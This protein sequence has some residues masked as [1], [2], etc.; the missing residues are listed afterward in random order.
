M[1]HD[2][3]RPVVCHVNLA[4]G[5]RGGER[6]TELLVCELARQGLRQRLVGRRGEPL[7]ERLRH[8]ER[9]EV[10]ETGAGP[11]AAALAIG[12]A[13][14]VHV[15]E[16][17]S[18]RSAW[19]NSVFTGTP[20]VVTRRVQKGPRSHM[21]NRH[22]YRRASAVAVLSRA[23]G[24][25]MSSLCPELVT[26]VIP[27]AASGLPSSSEQA[28]RLR[29]SWGGKF[30]VG[31]VGVLDDTHKGQTQIL[32]LAAG[33]AAT[34]PDVRFVLV[35]GG[36]DEARLRSAADG[37][38]NVVF[39]G[40]VDAVG[41]YLRAF[42]VFLFPSRHEGL[43]SILLDVLDFGI[44]VVATRVGGIPEIVED[45]VNGM[46]VEVG[47]IESMRDALLTL[48][49]DADLRA[50]IGAAGRQTAAAHTASTMAERYRML[51]RSVLEEKGVRT[52]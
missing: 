47:D 49:S 19:I 42:D 22:M 38:A 24:T 23:V 25:S 50:S 37:L 45:S 18:L 31:H 48:H 33:L 6:Q 34:L 26:T 10:L 28:E 9:L 36:P 41:D 8:L 43:G 21:L 2:S 3:C 51:Y 46:L 27:S 11:V 32:D 7:V 20:Y 14:L 30:V 44:P 15:H 29:K 1:P 40:Q 39:A 52:T 16:G 13:D 5:F 12:A 17:R 35:G 4:R